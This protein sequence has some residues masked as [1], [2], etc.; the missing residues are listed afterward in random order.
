MA[1]ITDPQ[2]VKFS[3][4]V[5][6]PIS[7]AIVGLKA[8]SD[9]ETVTWVQTIAPALAAYADGDTIVDG[10]ASDGRTP[11]SKSDLVDA[12]GV[13]AAVVAVVNLA[14]NEAKISKPHVNVKL[15]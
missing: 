3:N 8:L 14:G 4:E 9:A 5:M 7:D 15:P 11:L 13:L 1:D 2:V 6:R 10:S 12:I